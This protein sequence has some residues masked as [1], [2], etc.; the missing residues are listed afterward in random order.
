MKIQI[1]ATH[2]SSSLLERVSEKIP[3]TPTTG[4]FN[5]PTLTFLLNDKGTP[6][7]EVEYSGKGFLLGISQE[8]SKEG[9]K[10]RFFG[11]VALE[12]VLLIERGGDPESIYFVGGKAQANSPN[13]GEAMGST[14]TAK[15]AAKL[16]IPA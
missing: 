16:L 6:C 13:S 12:V 14:T 1:P 8:I 7:L 11:G 5:L 15:K 3:F 9:Q 10:V 4:S 2:S